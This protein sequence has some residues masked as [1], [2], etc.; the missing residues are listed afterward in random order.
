MPAS[1][2]SPDVGDQFAI[3]VVIDNAHN[4]RGYHLPV[5]FDPE[6][7][8]YVSWQQG[9]YLSGDVFAA[10][11]TIASDQISFV[12]TAPMTAE[13]THGILLTIT[14]EVVATKTSMLSLNDVILVSG[15]GV[16]LPVRTEESEIV[17]PMP[18]E[19]EESEIIEPTPMETE[20]SEIVEPTPAET[21][22]SGIVEPM[23]VETEESEVVEP[24]P[25]ETEESEA[26]EPTATETEESE[27]VERSTPAWDINEDGF[28]NILDLVLVRSNFGQEGP[29]PTDVNGDNVVNILDLTLVANH[30]GEYYEQP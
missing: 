20:E 18:A 21:E 5:Q 15:E 30:L 22:E 11:A 28:V 29:T 7:L 24:I 19:T 12:V 3:A 27:I 23:P 2:E 13:S 16:A 6:A 9:T 25:A 26:V 4:V 8:R 14:F 1:F 17:E 10:P